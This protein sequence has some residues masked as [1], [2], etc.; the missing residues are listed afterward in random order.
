MKSLTRSILVND[1][2]GPS[3]E[4]TQEE[5][6]GEEELVDEKQFSSPKLVLG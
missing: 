5:E 2:I 3:R 6:S 1:S 4:K